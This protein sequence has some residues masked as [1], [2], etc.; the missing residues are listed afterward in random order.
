MKSSL[1]KKKN[2]EEP[3]TAQYIKQKKEYLNVK[4][5]ILK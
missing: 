5:T 1:S 4:A 3:S 2:T